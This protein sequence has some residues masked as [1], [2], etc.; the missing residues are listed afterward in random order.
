VIHFDQNLDQVRNLCYDLYGA[1][2][3]AKT[4]ETIQMPFGGA[5]SC[6]SK[7]SCSLLDQDPTRERGN[8]EVVL[9]KS[10]GNLCCGVRLKRDH[11][12]RSAGVTFFSP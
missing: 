3:Y 1:A 12:I 8:Y 11:V 9:F 2:M 7:E 6:E 4:A 10:I 5:D